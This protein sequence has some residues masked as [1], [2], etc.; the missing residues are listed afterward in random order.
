MSISEQK[1]ESPLMRENS[2]GEIRTRELRGIR[3][4]YVNCLLFGAYTAGAIVLTY[5]DVRFGGWLDLD[6]YPMLLVAGVFML[7]AIPVAVFANWRITRVANP[8]K[9]LVVSCAIATTVLVV[10]FIPFE[11]ICI[12]FR[13]AIG[14]GL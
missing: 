10:A 7:S 13:L 9:R 8:R 3:H 4:I 12:A 11:M 1:C 5:M 6:Q 14:G 2:A